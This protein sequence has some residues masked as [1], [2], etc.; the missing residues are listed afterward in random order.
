MV[1][2]YVLGNSPNKRRG[3]GKAGKRGA[4]AESFEGDVV[5]DIKKAAKILWGV[6]GLVILSAPWAHGQ[7]PPSASVEAAYLLRLINE[8]RVAPTAMLQR[9]GIDPAWARDAMPDA[10]WIFD[11][12]LPPLARNDQLAASAQSHLQ[13]MVRR[14]YY[15]SVSPEGL[16]PWDRATAAGYAPLAVEETLG[17]LGV[18]TFV[19][20]PEAVWTIF[21]QWLIADITAAR[22]E[23]RR[24]FALW[25]TDVGPALQAVT[26]VLDG[27]LVNAYVA[28]CD[29]GKPELFLPMVVGSVRP[30]QAAGPFLDPWA[31]LPITPSVR[32]RTPDAALWSEALTDP[33][34][35]FRCPAAA[36]GSPVLI[37]VVDPITGD[38]LTRGET[39]AGET[40]VWLDLFF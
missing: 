32:C 23:D 6:L 34:G 18:L 14:L 4:V 17:L 33:L 10:A 26:V 8:A 7:E 31:V 16:G 25:P 1:S 3:S 39:V 21:R 29:F 30:A 9:A 19:D 13:D 27:V 12:G 2:A 20:W 15:S 11:T 35:G 5:A 22:P 24:I 36:P 37:D 28:V 40:H 38:V